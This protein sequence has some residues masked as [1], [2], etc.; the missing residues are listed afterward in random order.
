MC[1]GC[2]NLPS[3][4]YT[5]ATLHRPTYTSSSILL[6]HPSMAVQDFVRGECVVTVTVTSRNE[7]ILYRIPVNNT[8]GTRSPLSAT[9]RRVLLPN[10]CI[11]RSTSS[12]ATALPPTCRTTSP[13]R[14]PSLRVPKLPRASSF[15]FVVLVGI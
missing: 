13:S 7:I 1:S 11:W 8:F 3:G 4:F 15:V 12:V 14:P 6:V 9:L 2:L 10:R 5:A